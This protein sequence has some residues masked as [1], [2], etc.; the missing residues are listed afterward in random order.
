MSLI[1]RSLTCA[2]NLCLLLFRVVSLFRENRAILF[3]LLT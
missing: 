3:M 2:D 1:R